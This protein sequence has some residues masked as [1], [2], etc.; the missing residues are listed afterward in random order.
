MPA[1]KPPAFETLS[2]HAGQHPDPVTRSR[3]EPIYQTTS[4]LFDDADHAAGLFNL[5]RAGH[6]YTRISN[7]TTAVLEERLAALEQGVGAVCT[8]SGMAAMH[9]AIATLAGAGDHIVASASRSGAT[10]N[11][12]THTLPRFGVTTSFVKPRDL[13]GFRAA[14]G[15]NTRLVIAETIGNPGLEVLDIPQVAEIAHAVGIPLLID[16]TFATPYLSRPIDLGADLV[17][18]SITKWIGGHGIA[19]G[20]AIGDGGPFDLPGGRQ[21]PTVRTRH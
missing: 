18:H 1:P 12:L 17:M 16:N 14:I 10:I 8:A 15:E 6:I 5:E 21:F 3:A 9:L 19:L 11:L 7:P 13:D 4:Y 20:G 2:L